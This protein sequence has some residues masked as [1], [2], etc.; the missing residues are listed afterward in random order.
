MRA[1]FVIGCFVIGAIVSYY[2]G[3]YIFD[4]TDAVGI[5]VTVYTV[6]AGFLVAVIT[7]LGDP[8]LLP[9][10]S[11]E[12]AENHRDEIEGRLLRYNYLF[13]LYL[14]TIGVVFVGTLLAKA[15]AKVV[16]DDIKHWVAYAH[17]FLGASAF[18]LSLALPKMLIDVQRKRVDA[19][20]KRRRKDAGL[21]D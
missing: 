21:N 7:V 5:F 16:S 12:G 4:N 14:L 1:A 17:L 10:G 8:G 2:W 20:I 19:E 6:L 9:S 13:G 3:P 11:W 15:P 18:L